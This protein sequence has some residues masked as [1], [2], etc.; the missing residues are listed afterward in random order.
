MVELPDVYN[1]YCFAIKLFPTTFGNTGSDL[2]LVTRANDVISIEKWFS[3]LN[4]TLLILFDR[5]GSVLV[6][7][8]LHCLVITLLKLTDEGGWEVVVP[9]STTGMPLVLKV[10]FN[11]PEFKRGFKSGLMNLLDLK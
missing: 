9:G 5:L 1:N 8:Y 6:F 10:L 7:Y 2:Q 4:Y 3:L 11:R